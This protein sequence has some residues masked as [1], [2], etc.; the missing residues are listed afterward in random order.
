LQNDE[1][2][3]KDKAEQLTRVQLVVAKL[4]RSIDLAAESLVKAVAFQSE[5]VQPMLVHSKLESA[6]F[7]FSSKKKWPAIYSFEIPK[8]QE[9]DSDSTSKAETILHG[10]E[11]TKE[12]EDPKWNVVDNHKKKPFSLPGAQVLS[13]PVSDCFST[14]EFKIKST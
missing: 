5:S 4:E 1:K 13:S 10:V 9:S 6:H 2:D 11:I 12:L 3:W 14:F 8:K 7:A